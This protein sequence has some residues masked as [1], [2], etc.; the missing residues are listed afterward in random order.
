MTRAETRDA[1]IAKIRAHYARMGIPLDDLSDREIELGVR[2]L[3][4]ASRESGMT[5]E[6]ITE[7]M[8]KAAEEA[9]RKR[10]DQS[11]SA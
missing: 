3:A 11:N 4:V 2:Q 10:S 1:V 8:R 5:R 6:Q 7:A 9:R